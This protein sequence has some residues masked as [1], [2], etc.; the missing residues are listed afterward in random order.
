MVGAGV[1]GTGSTPSLSVTRPAH[2][3]HP[4]RQVLVEAILGVGFIVLLMDAVGHLYMVDVVG[5]AIVT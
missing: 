4:Q 1:T 5:T 3:Q 2:A